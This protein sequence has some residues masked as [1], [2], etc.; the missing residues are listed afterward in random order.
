MPLIAALFTACTEQPR[1]GAQQGDQPS[2]PAPGPAP[3]RAVAAA[4]LP[5]APGVYAPSLVALHGATSPAPGE[6]SLGNSLADTDSCA[7]CHPDAAAQWAQSAH[8]F[9]S[10]GNPIYRANVELLRKSLGEPA[11]RH[12]AGCHDM[13]LLFDGL[14]TGHTIPPEDLRSHSGVTCRLC[15]GVAKVTADGNGSYQWRTAPLDA[16]DLDDPRSVAAHKAEVS[17]DS[18]GTEL[19]VGCH[20]GFLS[21]DL[22]VPV[23]LSGIDE[24]T[25]WRSSPWM[26]NGMARIDKVAKQTCIDCH[27]EREPASKEELGAQGGTM[28]SH[29]FLGGHTW[30]AAM[31]G[32]LDHLARTRAKLVGAASIDVAGA[33]RADGTWHLPADGAPVPPSGQTLALDVVVRNLL[34]GHRFPGGVLDMHDTWIEVE[35][36]DRAGR[37]LAAS[38]LA[39]EQSASDQEAHVL[40]SLVVDEHGAVR[41]KHE[42]S[43]FR[44]VIAN[45]TLAAREAHVVRYAFTVPA[46]T[47]Q[48]HPLSVTARLRHRA[49]TLIQQG[50][51]CDVARSA[52]GKKFLQGAR[53]ARDVKIDP[54]APQPITLIAE[55]TVTLAGLAPSKPSSR[56]AW[57]RMYEH[58]MALTSV[59]SERLDEARQ[60]LEAARAE[61]SAA[62]GA[63]LRRLR[64]RAGGT[65][66]TGCA[67]GGCAGGGRAVSRGGDDLGPA[68]GGGGQAGPR[69]RRARVVDEARRRLSPPFPAALDAIATD[70]LG[71]VWRWREAVPLAQRAAAAAP[72]NTSAWAT[73][74]KVL[75]SAGDD[76]G[77]L[78]AAQRGLALAPRDSDLLRSQATAL[79]ALGSPEAPAALAAFD[80]FRAP[81]QAAELRIVCAR[82]S[83][84]CNR[85]RELGHTHA[86]VAA[87]AR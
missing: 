67:G 53:G 47:P 25:A 56:P 27:M 30:M 77:A 20:R 21:P 49:R 51:V 85:E 26:G 39:H 13:P 15:H 75:A 12:C 71:R 78:A 43:T 24:P 35:V 66:C 40:R 68:R 11:S 87:P 33:R 62:C 55:S 74:A 2:R 9:A 6:P 69:R 36:R 57:E 59:V 65:G 17:V 7:S 54:C 1:T 31:R 82:S 61:V 14:M 41:E 70:A 76:A 19:C 37:R 80:R 79:A 48:Q 10:F 60:V 3:G 5:S 28:A 81:D 23:H 58:G 86:L 4:A 52:D 34:V 64:G 22:G 63:R 84:R 73:L 16:P 8:S 18:L 50:E 32:D 44:G 83:P 38:G 46:L 45:H 72:G 29:R 42:L